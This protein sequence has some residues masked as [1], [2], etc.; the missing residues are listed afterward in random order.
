MRRWWRKAPALAVLLLLLTGCWDLR[1]MNQ[2]ALVMA[3]GIDLAE[4][5]GRYLVTVQVARPGAGKGGR[6]GA[7]S[8]DA[9]GRKAVYI[10][11]AD[12][13]TI[14]AAIRNLAQFTSRRIMWAHNNVIVIGEPLAR[15]GITPVIDFFTRNQELRMRTWVVV[16]RGAEAQEIVSAQTGMETVPANSISAILR[17]ASLPGEAPRTDVSEVSH[18]FMNRELNTVI[19]AV[20]LKDRLVN[21]EEPQVELRGAAIFN[22]PRLAGYV[23][24]ETG[25]GLLWLR[26]E[27]SNAVITVPCPGGGGNMAVELRSPVSRVTPF[28][29][30]GRPVFLVTVRTEGWLSEQDCTT[31]EMD[32]LALKAMVEREMSA[33]IR[34]DIEQTVAYLQEEIGVDGAGFGRRVHVEHPAWWR[35]HGDRWE[36]IF[37]ESPVEIQVRVRLSKMG[38]YTRPLQ[39]QEP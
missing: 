13:D 23:E 6:G 17:H 18:S 39:P 7:G 15:E 4:T 5:P 37:P 28:L 33:K 25:R 12:G 10:A 34:G 30:E 38:I 21:E 22:G 19:S 26:R 24:S 35:A 14:F 8:G 2:L 16:A 3:V 32:S 36:E 29:Q 9:S 1:E 11:S 31:P 27:M 20:R